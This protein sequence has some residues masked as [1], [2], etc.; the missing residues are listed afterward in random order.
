MDKDL[1]EMPRTF[2]DD[3]RREF[4]TP[5]WMFTWAFLLT[6]GTAIALLASPRAQGDELGAAPPAIGDVFVFHAPA[7]DGQAPVFRAAKLVAIDDDRLSFVD[8]IYDYKREAAARELVADD[9]RTKLDY[10]EG[11]SFSTPR[12]AENP[13]LVFI[14][15]PAL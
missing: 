1:P 4:R 15:H 14:L 13:D 10:F 12:N 9:T 3:V 7:S 2:M 11:R 6:I 8:S 5:A